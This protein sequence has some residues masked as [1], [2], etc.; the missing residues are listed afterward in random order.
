[1]HALKVAA[2][3]LSAGAA[4]IS[5]LTF[6]RASGVLKDSKPPKP[7][8]ANVVWV[9][10]MPQAD[11]ARSIGDTIQLIATLK[12]DHGSLVSGTPS[13][14]VDDP[15]V[16]SVDSAGTVVALKEG[17]TT[18]V[19][20]A[21]ERV[22]RARVAVRPVVASVQIQ[23]DSSF[24][25][26]EGERRP[27]S[28]V[29]LDARGHALAGW[30]VQWSSSDS[31]IAKIDSVGAITGVTPGRT[32]L[33]ARVQGISARIEIAVVPVA[34][35]VAIVAGKGQRAQAGRSLPQPVMV[36]VLSRG[37]RPMD[38]VPVRFA[39]E[40]ASTEETALTDAAGRARSTWTLADRPGR[41]RLTVM[42]TG[43]D[44]AVTVTA[45][46]DPVPANTRLVLAS[47]VAGAPA[48]DTL[49]S[50]VV[51]SVTD[52]TGAPLID[53]PVDWLALDGG[54]ATPLAER[55]DSLGHARASWKL[56][57]K[58]GSQRMRVQVGDSREIPAL[59]IKSKAEPGSPYALTLVSGGSQSG[60]VSSTLKVPIAIRVSDR[61]GNRISG[62]AVVLRPE[63]GSVGDSTLTTDSAGVAYGR[64]T[65]GGTAGTQRLAVHAFP[66]EKELVIT[67][68]GLARSPASLGFSS[69]PAQGSVGRSLPQPLKVVVK[70]A[71]GNPIANRT[72]TFVPVGGKVSP[73]RAVTD[74][75]G[76]ATT[77]W[78]LGTTPGVQTLAAAVKDSEVKGKV[79]VKAVKPPPTP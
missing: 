3:T 44:S 56:G 49:A 36:Q 62:A 61:L 18:V 58:S 10:I 12:D 74:A 5:I 35:S 54:K 63:A 19:A 67:A 48:G 17:I 71:Y 50:P 42:V 26:P 14:S 33:E 6:A 57:S 37:G 73:A 20:A 24:R 28:A 9:G 38:G 59:T 34:A 52:S 31:S 15:T 22:A 29:T 75:H 46:A 7:S 51:V 1:M 16:A 66:I 21:G 76:V 60:G 11:T 40:P 4:T 43:V 27:A 79:T 65:L 68:K 64:W 2:G 41:Q 53:I 72:V 55:T 69:P 25:V 70:D 47:P 32:M 45:E 30:P 77:K 78:T 23:F 8:H 13:W 39:A